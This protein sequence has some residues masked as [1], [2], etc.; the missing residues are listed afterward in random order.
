MKNLDL[1]DGYL[2]NT[3]S[4]AEKAEFNKR[5]SLDQEFTKEFQEVKEIQE[6]IK[7]VSRKEMLSFLHEVEEQVTT[8]ESTL[9]NHNM[10]RSIMTAA[11]VVLIAAISFFTLS[12]NSVPSMENLYEA[13][14]DSYDN[15]NGQVRG[16]AQESNSLTTQAYNAYDMGNY[17]LAALSFAELVKT[18]KSAENYLYMGLSNLEANNTEEA[19]KNLNATIN[20][21]DLFSAQAKW[22]LAMAHLKNKDENAAV[23]TLVGL[24]LEDSKYKEQ[25]EAILKEMGLSVSSLDG[26]V[27]TDVKLRPK[28]DD[29]PDGTYFEERRQTQFGTVVSDRDGFRYNFFTDMPIYGLQAGAEVE[30]IVV[31]KNKRRKTGF[32][33]LLGE[34]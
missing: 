3:L 1:I 11:S 15:I 23:S 13:N 32:A 2:N 28:N 26:G 30:M 19:I 4:D 7:S 21:F 33:F 9:N 24:T 5:L 12:N 22:Y 25:A 18:N 34:Y 20:N 17:D 27:V 8:Q 16:E 6:G 14:F 10:K 29:A 31:R